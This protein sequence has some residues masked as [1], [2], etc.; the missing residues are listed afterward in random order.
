M[1]NEAKTRRIRDKGAGPGTLLS[2]GCRIKGTVTGKGH[3]MVSGEVEG[4]GE[5]DGLVTLGDTGTWRG[6]I[7]ANSVIVAGTVEGD[8]EATGRVEIGD[9]AKI[10]GTVSGDAIAV[11]EGAVVEGEMHTTG[12]DEPSEFVERRDMDDER[13]EGPN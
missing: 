7:K 6:K 10:T 3:L 5:I 13:L 8:I 2:E 4:D 12:H 1:S 11:A 9:T